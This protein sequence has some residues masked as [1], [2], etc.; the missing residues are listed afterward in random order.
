MCIIFRLDNKIVIV[1]TGINP[2]ESKTILVAKKTDID[3]SADGTL[4]TLKCQDPDFLLR[5]LKPLTLIN[6]SH[7][8]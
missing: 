7:V 5:D 6:Q 1:M 3:Y 2:N 8:C 4:L